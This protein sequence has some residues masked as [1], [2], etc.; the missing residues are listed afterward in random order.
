M[1]TSLIPDCLNSVVWLQ[2]LPPWKLSAALPSKICEQYFSV[3]VRIWAIIVILWKHCPCARI[4]W[5]AG[6]TL[7]LETKRV[8]QR[9]MGKRHRKGKDKMAKNRQNPPWKDIVKQNEKFEKYYKVWMVNIYNTFWQKDELIIF[10]STS[11][12]SHG[13]PLKWGFVSSNYGS[14]NI[15]ILC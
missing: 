5:P 12:I 2:P 3:T 11:F 7:K 8:G 13:K 4:D 14:L 6:G 9:N 10:S 15:E 1:I